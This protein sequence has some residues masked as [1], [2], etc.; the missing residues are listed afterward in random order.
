MLKGLCWLA[1]S[2]VSRTPEHLLVSSAHASRGTP[3]VLVLVD[4]AAA[5]AGIAG[6]FFS[7][8]TPKL[9]DGILVPIGGQ[10]NH[11]DADMLIPLLLMDLAAS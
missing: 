7:L 2:A 10:R 5:T 11:V 6:N 1:S 9:P 8:F 4:G 3:V